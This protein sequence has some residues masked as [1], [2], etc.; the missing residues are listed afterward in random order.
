MGGKRSPLSPEDGAVWE[1]LTRGVKPLPGR[2]RPVP[3]PLG[4]PPRKAKPQP[5][6]PLQSESPPP[7]RE[8]PRVPRASPPPIED[9]ILKSIRRGQRAIDVRLDLH[10]E[11]QIRAHKRLEHA[12]AGARARGARVVLVVTGTGLRRKLKDDGPRVPIDEA[13]GVLRRML[14]HWLAT[15]PLGDWVIGVS[16]AGR[17]HGGAGAFYVLLRRPRAGGPSR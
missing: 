16:Q 8:R 9:R 14:P 4:P 13:P 10:G 11:T 3:A 7:V 6:T 15:P 12:L 1:A 2:K 5:K 17:G